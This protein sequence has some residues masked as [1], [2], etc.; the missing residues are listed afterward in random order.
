ME[1]LQ[2]AENFQKLKKTVIAGK[3]IDI[4]KID[5]AVVPPLILGYDE[6]TRIKSKLKFLTNFRVQRDH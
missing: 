5:P 2:I 6:E 3:K 4:L 1:F